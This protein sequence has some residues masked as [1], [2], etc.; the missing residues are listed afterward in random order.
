MWSAWNAIFAPAGTP[1]PIVDKLSKAIAA[2]MQSPA[3]SNRL[4]EQGTT[5]LGS[6]PAELAAVDRP[7]HQEIRA[8][9]WRPPASSS[10]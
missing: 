4:R 6:T 8:P 5:A 1:Q 2:I 9:R 10:Q 3:I 7:R